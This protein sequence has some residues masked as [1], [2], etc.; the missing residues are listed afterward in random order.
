[1]V[2]SLVRVRIRSE[3]DE[4]Y[5]IHGKSTDTSYEQFRAM[6]VKHGLMFNKHGSLFIKQAMMFVKRRIMSIKHRMMF[7][8][9]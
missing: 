1:M 5:G 3:V 4:V 2:K 6:F 8:K 9:H 7:V